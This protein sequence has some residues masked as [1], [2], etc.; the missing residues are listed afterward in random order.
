MAVKGID[1]AEDRS[2]FLSKFQSF[3]SQK[4][5]EEYVFHFASLTEIE[6]KLQLDWIAQFY[7]YFVFVLWLQIAGRYF[8]V[9]DWTPR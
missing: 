3:S 8:V 9:N 2:A 5:T 1:L 7:I 4:I 6:T